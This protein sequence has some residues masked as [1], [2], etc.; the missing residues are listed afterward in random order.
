MK[1]ERVATDILF[2]LFNEIGIIDQ[3][4]RT[5]LQRTLPS[6]LQVAHFTLLNHCVR[7][8]D[9]KT[10]AEL[11][12]AFQVTKGALTNTVQRLEA[13]GLVR[14]EADAEDARRKRVYLTQAGRTVRDEAIA[15]AAAR[16]ADVGLRFSQ[17]EVES[18]LPFLQALRTHLDTHRSETGGE[19]N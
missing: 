4:A 2:A 19:G 14:V 5:R 3:L 10:P 11:A 17:A 13:R 18:A 1:A 9:G 7:L 8:G 15:A 6:G 16:F 12:R